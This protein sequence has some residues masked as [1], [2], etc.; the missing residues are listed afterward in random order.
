NPYGRA[1]GADDDGS[2]STTIFEA[3]RLLVTSGFEPT[4]S[5]EFQWYSAE[6]GGLLGSQKIAAA[7]R[8]LEVPIV[9][10]IQFDMTGYHPK[11][12]TTENIAVG[13]DNVDPKL[14]E[15]VKKLAKEYSNLPVKDTSCG[16][17]CSDHASFNK[18]GYS[19]AFATE[20]SISDGSPYIHTTGD[21]L[22]TINYDHMAEFVKLAVAYAVEI[23]LDN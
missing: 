18:A 5:I 12:R 3:F 22:G 4:R 7:Y 15:F 17:G 2:G 21:N 14:T 20:A 8:Q 10:M 1:P 23:S 6:E 19:S 13:I 16:Y 9:A 11:I